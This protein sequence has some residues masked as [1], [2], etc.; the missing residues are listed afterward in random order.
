MISWASLLTDLEHADFE[1]RR[2]VDPTALARWAFHR[3]RLLE[4]LEVLGPETASQE[5]R[6]RLSAALVR[7]RELLGQWNQDRLRMRAEAANL[8]ASR[9]LLQSLHPARSG[10]HF[11]FD[12]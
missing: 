7:G 1:L 11:R 5:D 6:V 8:H 3:A 2:C 12:T 9:L 10:A 4:M